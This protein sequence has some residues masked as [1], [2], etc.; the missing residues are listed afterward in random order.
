MATL[1]ALTPGRAESLQASKPVVLRGFGCLDLPRALPGP[2][3]GALQ[4]PSNRTLHRALQQSLPIGASSWP[5][6]GRMACFACGLFTR[7]QKYWSLAHSISACCLCDIA[8]KIVGRNARTQKLRSNT[9]HL[10]GSGV[11]Y[12]KQLQIAQICKGN[13][14]RKQLVWVKGDL[15]DKSITRSSG[16]RF[17]PPSLL[18]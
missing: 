9:M 17:A 11:R 5:S 4:G 1:N 2:S 14:E 10:E 15:L 8:S 3:N 13:A 18:P 12:C 7:K 16:P 6:I